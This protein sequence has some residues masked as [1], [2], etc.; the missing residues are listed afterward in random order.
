M[1]LLSVAVSGVHHAHLS[2]VFL[3]VATIGLVIPGHFNLPF[4]RCTAA[5]NTT[6]VVQFWRVGRMAFHIVNMHHNRP[7]LR[8]MLVGHDN[9]SRT[10][11]ALPVLTVGQCFHNLQHLAVRSK[12]RCNVLICGC[13]MHLQQSPNTES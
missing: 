2:D 12:Q 8:I 4:K 9:M 11:Q 3:I 6:R 1:L 13:R 7:Y 5:C 10:V